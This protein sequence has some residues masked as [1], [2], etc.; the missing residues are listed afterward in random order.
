MPEQ[1]QE[2]TLGRT[3]LLPDDAD[4]QALLAL[5]HPGDWQNPTPRRCYDLAVLGGGSGG[6]VAAAAAAGLGAR[7]ALVERDLLGGDCLNAGCVP[8]KTLLRSAHW[9]AEMR[10]GPDLGWTTSFNHPA[11]PSEVLRR[12]RRV[13]AAL[14]PTDSARRFRDDLGVDV[15]FGEARF[16]A[17]NRVEV[18]GVG[19][20]FRRAII[21]TG[22]RPNRPLIAGL[23]PAEILTNETIFAL[24]QPPRRLV[25]LGGGPVGCELAQ[26]FARLGTQCLLVQRNKRLLPR[27]EEDASNLV[28]SALR[29]DGVEILLE[30]ELESAVRR[31]EGLVAEIR[32]GKQTRSV[33]V[34]SLLVATGR[35]P[36]TE[37]L[38][39]DSAGIATRNDGSIATDTR[40]RT[41]NRRVFAVGDVTLSER[42]THAADA[43]ARIAVRN[44]LFFGRSRYLPERIPRSTYTDPEVA[45]IGLL[46]TEAQ[47]RGIAYETLEVRFEENDRAR[48]EEQ[49]AGFVRAHFAPKSGKLLGATVVGDHAGDLIGEFAVLLAA[50][51]PLSRLADVVHPYPTRAEAVRRIGDLYNRRRLTPRAARLL[52]AIARLPRR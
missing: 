37:A 3:R 26:A 32:Q 15:F 46:P 42:F 29:A 7:V 43:S 23:D 10:R 21:A 50:V 48:T 24:A 36:N 45:S 28:E 40:L 17:K 49:V 51:M 47:G 38:H 13:R 1:A 8:S 20:G 52:R 44:A 9:A 34:D 33:I 18:D 6:L 27:E 2:E 12:V 22:A 5:V 31:P 14:A 16:F 11:T 35:R 30:A 39:L 25:V 19:L 4:D 41:A